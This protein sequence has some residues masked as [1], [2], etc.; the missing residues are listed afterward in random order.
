MPLQWFYTGKDG[1]RVGPYTPQKL[2]QMASQGRLFP[3]YKIRKEGTEQPVRAHN[4]EGPF[5]P[6]AVRPWSG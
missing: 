5:T 1:K 2:E 3:A 6:P 4:A